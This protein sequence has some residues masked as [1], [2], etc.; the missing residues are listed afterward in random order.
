MTPNPPT[1]PPPDDEYERPVSP[2]DQ[3]ITPTPPPPA[4]PLPETE[5]PA[6]R[7]RPTAWK[8][9]SWSA[10]V[11]LGLVVC[12]CIGAMTYVG[13]T[14]FGPVNAVTTKMAPPTISVTTSSK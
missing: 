6:R 4:V 1:P 13:F 10:I 9:L 12:S 5:P 8:P 11:I 3:H 2:G 7:R 14:C